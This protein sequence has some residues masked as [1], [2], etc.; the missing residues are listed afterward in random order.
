MSEP[1]RPS[2]FELIA[3]YFAP[4]ARGEPGAFGLTDD[5]AVL[6]PRPGRDLVITTDAIVAGVHFLPGD[7]AETIAQKALRVNLSDLAAK[8]ATPRAYL[9]TAAFPHD[10]QE[11]WLKAFA[12]GL[13]RDQS[14]F[15]IALLGGDTVATPGPLSL[16]VTALGDIASGRML[17]RGGAKV[18]DDVWVTGTIGDATLGLKILMGDGKG[19]NDKQRAALIARFRVP[20]PR[21]TLGPSLIGVAHACLDI[22]D[23]LIADFGHMSDVSR[24]AIEIQARDVPISHA[25]AAAIAAGRASLAELLT[26]G[27]DYELAIAAPPSARAKL[28]ALAKQTRIRL[29]RIGSVAKGRGVTALDGEGAPLNVGRGGFTHW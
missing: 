1:K 8:G 2:E 19:L 22:S 6:K 11:M 21:T 9:M 27:D 13:K 10:V 26:G 4:L 7:P 14:R 25:A 29:T 28:A 23:G 16:S 5:A 15:A 18:G 17:T 12:Q 20:E 3:K 24:V